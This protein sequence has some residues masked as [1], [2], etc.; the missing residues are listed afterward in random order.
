MGANQDWNTPE[1]A[2][3]VYD[4]NS[5][6]WLADRGI[7]VNPDGTI[8]IRQ[9][10]REDVT[11]FGD[12]FEAEYPEFKVGGFASGDQV[13]TL[14]IQVGV[15]G[16]QSARMNLDTTRVFLVDLTNERVALGNVSGASQTSAANSVLIGSYAGDS[17]TTANNCTAVGFNALAGHVDAVKATAFGAYAL[18]NNTAQHT[19]G[20]G[21]E[22]GYTQTSG[23]GN[24]YLGFRAG[25]TNATGSGV[26]Q[27]GWYAGRY[28]TAGLITSVGMEAGYNSGVGST[29]L[30][31]RAGKNTNSEY[32]LCLGASCGE[33]S[34]GANDN[35]LIGYN[36][37]ATGDTATDE[38]W[39]GNKNS[40]ATPL[41]CGDLASLTLGIGV[42]SIPS[43]KVAIGFDGGTLELV[44]VSEGGSGTGDAAIEVA[45]GSSTYYIRMYTSP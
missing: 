31:Y 24:T 18:L 19:L 23:S 43:S 16:A 17:I 14:G 8:Y 40:S 21:T 28:P 22:A 10:G 6:S 26:T 12:A 39:L 27:V 35:I 37:N 1:G 32:T 7:M 9:D 42:S 5:D 44:D 34:S 45:I 2:I 3:Q 13:R 38:F 30:G 4:P 33:T 11:V 20:V 25:Y 36:Q 41:L 29:Y 15:D